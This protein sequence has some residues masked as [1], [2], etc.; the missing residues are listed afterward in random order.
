MIRQKIKTLKTLSNDYFLSFTIVKF[1][2][3]SW[4]LFFK[5]TLFKVIFPYAFS[6]R[7][8]SHVPVFWWLF[9]WW[10]FFQVTFFPG[11]F[12]LVTCLFSGAFFS[13]DFYYRWLFFRGKKLRAYFFVPFFLVTF[14]PDDFFPRKKSHVTF[15]RWLFFRDI[16]SYNTPDYGENDVEI[17]YFPKTVKH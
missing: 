3:G 17:C 12:F 2:E 9:L 10:L 5:L 11:D 7:K 16:M 1:W 15:F 14:F 4:W 13:C 6:F 8:I